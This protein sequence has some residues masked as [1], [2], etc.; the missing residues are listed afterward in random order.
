MREVAAIARVSIKTV[1]RV[2]NGDSPVS[3][4]LMARVTAAIDH[5]DYHL[6]IAASTLRRSDGKSATIGVVLEDVSSPFSSALARSIEDAVLERGFLVLLGS[7]DENAEREHR[8]VSAF[9]SRRVDGMVIVPASHYHSYLLNECRAGA[10]IVFADSPPRFLD[11]DAVITDNRGGARSGIEHLISHGHV[12]IGY[13][14]DA[15]TIAGADRF[16]GYLDELSTQHIPFDENLVRVDLHGVASAESAVGEL[17]ASDKPPTAL[18]T[19]QNLITIG[20]YKTLRRLGLH[21]NIGLVGFGDTHLI[22]LVEPGL[23]VIAQDPAL[24][25]QT[26]VKLLFRRLD[27]DRSLPVRCVIPTRLFVRGSGEIRL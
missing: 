22:G 13:L 4:D 1:S 16:Q 2:V 24:I 12:R 11:A 14:G 15:R 26:A 6:N 7:S 27:G 21:Q 3:P 20:A 9:M 25:G 10:A 17:L 23:T 19:A 8:L 18:F 5:L